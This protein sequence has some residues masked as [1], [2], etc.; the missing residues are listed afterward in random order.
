MTVT[1]NKEA[2]QACTVV[3]QKY[4][5]VTA[6]TDVNVPDINPDI[7]KV[8]DVSGNV[9]VSEKS[10][11][12]GKIFIRGKVSMTVLYTPDGDTVSKV[13]CLTAEK[14]FTH[15]A[16]A[17]NLDD[18]VRMS[19]EIE[20]ES[21]NYTLINS[22]KLSLRCVLAI[23]IKLSCPEEFEI[24]TS[25]Q[26]DE[27]ICTRSRR[28]RLCSNPITS[29]NR[30]SICEQFELPS[31]KPS[32][33]E[34]LKTS[35]FPQSLEFTLM[36]GKALAKGQARICT[37]YT[38]VDD[39]TVCFI[40]HT[41]PFSEFLDV[42]GAE[43]DMEGEIDYSV[44]D[45]YSEIRDDSDG[46]PRII[47]LDLGLSASVRGHR[48]YEPQ[49]LCDAYSMHGTANITSN[50]KLLEQLVDNTTAQL[51]HKFSIQ[52]PAA[53]PEISQLCDVNATASVSNISAENGEI[54][55]TGNISGNII[56]LSDDESMPLCSFTDTSEFTHNIPAPNISSDSVCEAKI[57]VEHI[58]YTINGSRTIE[59]RVVLGL[60]IR[61]YINEEIPV[62]TDID[63]EEDTDTAPKPCIVIYFVK[64]GD[65][66][67]SIA[68][69]Y[70][71]TVESL[72]ECNNLSSD[73]INVGQQIRICRNV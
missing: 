48:I 25:G 46:E 37:V 31:D 20:P 12:S 30:I 60:C 61:S 72:M 10:V 28:L 15:S 38:S 34:I 56:Y 29:E 49:I 42:E 21:F 64:S 45:I 39:G 18:N 41:L 50:T 54:T 23:D 58:S 1:L 13:K 8:L 44:S 55:V 27:N 11:H 67:W 52:L 68:K 73:S 59:L 69:K 14:E 35:V 36:D 3:Y 19:A 4:S 7:L 22:R 62:I 6:E 53:F 33:S 70:R 2:I 9:S 57:F 5:R 40:E 17:G 32:V 47:G 71:T 66:L 24:S 16:D 63:I 65:S 51:T 43:E 26:A